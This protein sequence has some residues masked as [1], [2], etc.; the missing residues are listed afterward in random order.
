MSGRRIN[1]DSPL[2]ERLQLNKLD[3]SKPDVPKR[4]ELPLRLNARREK[5][6]LRPSESKERRRWRRED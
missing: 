4:P 3:S 2:K 5:L 1:K 6:K